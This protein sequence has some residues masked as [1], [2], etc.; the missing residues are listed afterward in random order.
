VPASPDAPLTFRLATV[1]DAARLS[2]FAYRL[3][4]ASF[5]PDNHPRDM[6]MYLPAAFS[7]SKQTSELTDPS[8]RYLLGEHN[9]E[10]AAYALVRHGSTDAEVDGPKPVEIERFYVDTPWH[11]RGAAQA[12]M[13]R[14]ITLARELGGETLWLGVW[15]K[16]A[17]AIRFYTRLGFGDVGSHPYLLGTDWQTD[18]VMSQRIAG[19]P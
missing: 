17:R 10:L 4:D 8:R 2:A 3:F 16:N 11:G 6:A 7:E 13:Q 5:G 18:R 19:A 15:E 14:V 9:G 12:M 1:A